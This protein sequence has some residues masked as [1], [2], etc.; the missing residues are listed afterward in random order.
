MIAIRV[1]L[2][3]NRPSQRC[4]NNGLKMLFEFP[5]SIKKRQFHITLDSPYQKNL[6]YLN[7][8]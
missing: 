6:I 8:E 1:I 2:N 4:Y 5:F 7:R 3:E